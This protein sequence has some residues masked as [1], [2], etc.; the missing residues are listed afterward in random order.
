VI[1]TP[2]QDRR[3]RPR[4]LVLSTRDDKLR[5]G[6]S[7]IRPQAQRQTNFISEF[8]RAAKANDVFEYLTGEEVVPPKPRKDDYFTKPGNAEIRRSTRT[9]NISTPTGDLG[10]RLIY[11][12]TPHL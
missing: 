4:Y 12:P 10:N 2:D 11:H 9:K 3:P 8:E 7:Q 1:K 6:R 5:N